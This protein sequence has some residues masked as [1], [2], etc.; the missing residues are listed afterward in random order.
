[1]ILYRLIRCYL[2]IGL[3]FF[4][5]KITVS[6][7]ENIP[8]NGAILYVANH[9]NAMIDP[10][11]IA[12]ST[13]S[14]FFLTRASA[15]KNKLVSKFLRAIQMIAIYR[16]RDGVDS[17]AL[18]EAVFEECL[19]VFT[20]NKSIL[21][22]PEGSHSI[23]RQ[24]RPL[25]YGFTRMTIDYLIANPD[26]DLQIVPIGLNYTNTKNYA[27]E[28]YLIFGKPIKSRELLVEDDLQKTK[29]NLIN[30][31]RD[32]LKKI[33]VHIEEDNYAEVFNSLAEKDYLNP[34]I[35]NKKIKSANFKAVTIPS[36]SKNIFY[37][38]MQL[39]SIIPFL[40]WFW[41]RKKIEAKEFISTAKYSLGL[42]VFP[43]FYGLQTIAVAVFFGNTMAIYYVALCFILVFLSTKTR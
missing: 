14:M 41:L 26:K 8:D 2:K 7:K 32:N 23:K 10:L 36:K 13:K 17:K 5:K 38:L 15:F 40:I 16:V 34:I 33:T 29:S 12:T 31:V 19:E 21:I 28:V 37:H 6:G 1:M 22:F 27:E 18:N 24:V 3:Y 20:K 30:E 9:Q 42:T 35:T 4:Y 25:R 43:L 39:N 11:I